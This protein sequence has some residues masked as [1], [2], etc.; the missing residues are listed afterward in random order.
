MSFELQPPPALLQAQFNELETT[1]G[2]DVSADKTRQL[3][4]YLEQAELSSREWQL[5]LTDFEER[6]FAGSVVEAFGAA[7]RILIRQW[8]LKHERE[9]TL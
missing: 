3:I 5:K 9:L 1:V 6:Q 7:K 8:Q 4:S 2:G